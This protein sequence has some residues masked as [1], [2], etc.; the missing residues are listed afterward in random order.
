MNI[1]HIDL[2]KQTPMIHSH[3]LTMS[4]RE[5]AELTGKR[6]ADV[7]RDIRSKETAYCEVYGSQRKFALAKYTDSQGKP[8]DEFRLDKSQA[9]FVVSGY[10][11]VRRAK[12]QKRMEDLEQELSQKDPAKLSRIEI[13]QMALESER[14]TLAFKVKIEADAP[15][16]EFANQVSVSQD[17]IS[18]SEAAKIIGIGQKRLFSFLRHN[19]GLLALINLT[20]E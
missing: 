7:M 12:V 6:H 18:V 8:R 20:N 11:S 16:V 19:L 13:L 4:S 9:L 17:A 10:D 3:Q 2:S 14:N 1:T 15:K 5:I